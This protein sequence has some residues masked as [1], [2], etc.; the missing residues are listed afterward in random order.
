MKLSK[1]ARPTLLELN[2][3][4]MI[5]VV[6]NLLI[7]F[8]VI[9]SQVSNVQRTKLDLPKLPGAEDQQETTLTV[10]VASDGSIIVNT[11]TISLTELVSMVSDALDRAGG[12]VNLVTVVIRAD[13]N[14]VSRPVNEIVS[15]LTRMQIS[16]V[17]FAV[18]VPK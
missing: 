11:E 7:F 9:S 6:F 2:M 13:R 3:T 12:D 18:E 10:N 14:G 17:R 1:R 16:R 5:D 8:M 4:P 15:A